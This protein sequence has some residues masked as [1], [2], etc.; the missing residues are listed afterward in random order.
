V[1][2][3]PP[4]P[5][6]ISALLREANFAEYDGDHMGFDV[7]EAAFS[8]EVEVIVELRGVDLL[9]FNP[10]EGPRALVREYAAAIRKVGWSARIP[11]DRVLVTAPPAGSGE[12][13][14]TESNEG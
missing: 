9:P 13:V 12:G 14:P 11:S 4:T 6:A 3:K 8:P 2:T 1:V 10:G 7:F 5:Q